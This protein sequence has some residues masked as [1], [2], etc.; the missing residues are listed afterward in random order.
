VVYDLYRMGVWL[1][2]DSTYMIGFYLSILRGWGKDKGV[3]HARAPPAAGPGRG[4]ARF[5]HSTLVI[6]G[7]STL[8]HYGECELAIISWVTVSWSPWL[9][10]SPPRCGNKNPRSYPPSERDNRSTD[11]T[12]PLLDGN[13]RPVTSRARGCGRPGAFRTTA[14]L[15]PCSWCAGD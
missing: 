5:C 3:P 6:A 8:L 10:P 4:K 2:I 15:E 1:N 11:T 14:R 9:A 7:V 13:L 12:T